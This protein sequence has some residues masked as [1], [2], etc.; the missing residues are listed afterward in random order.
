L[1]SQRT[2]SADGRC[3]TSSYEQRNSDIRETNSDILVVVRQL[4]CAQNAVVL[5]AAT[6]INPLLALTLQSARDLNVP[7]NQKR[8]KALLLTPKKTGL[9]LKKK[10]YFHFEQKH[11]TLCRSD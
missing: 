6:V 8:S 2:E 3:V 5:V 4:N 9:S 1:T 10:M 7:C 11:L